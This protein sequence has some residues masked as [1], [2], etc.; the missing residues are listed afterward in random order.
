MALPEGKV[1]NINSNQTNVNKTNYYLLFIRQAKK[2]KQNHPKMVTFA[3]T[4][5]N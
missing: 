2:P 1:F 5:I 4:V 3:Y